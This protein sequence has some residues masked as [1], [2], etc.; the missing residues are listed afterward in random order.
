[1]T[2]ALLLMLVTFLPTLMLCRE[3]RRST[4]S[5][6]D[7]LRRSLGVTTQEIEAMVAWS[8]PAYKLAALFGLLCAVVAAFAFGIVRV[9]ADAPLTGDETTGLALYLAAFYLVCLPVLGS[10]ARMPGS[11]AQSCARKGEPSH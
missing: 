5:P 8:P 1:M 10:A 4:R 11:Y 9:Q 3:F 7:W 6:A 2:A